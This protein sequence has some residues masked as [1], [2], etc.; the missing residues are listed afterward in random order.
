MSL[1]VKWSEIFRPNEA[2][3][4]SLNARKS[5]LHIEN[6]SWYQYHINIMDKFWIVGKSSSSSISSQCAINVQLR[7][8]VHFLQNGI[9]CPIYK[10]TPH[11][12]T[13]KTDIWYPRYKMECIGHSLTT[14]TLTAIN[15]VKEVNISPLTRNRSLSLF[16]LGVVPLFED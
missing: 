2:I 4:L 15:C 13:W 5:Q 3:N 12:Q 8:T 6:Q 16:C 10:M 9:V 7:Q 11:A 14:A 1:N